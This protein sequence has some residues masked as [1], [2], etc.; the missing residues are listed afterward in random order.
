MMFLLP[1]TTSLISWWPPF[2]P[3]VDLELFYEPSYR[4]TGVSAFIET[5]ALSDKISV[6]F[7]EGEI[8]IRVKLW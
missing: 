7:R 8:F 6:P 3:K 4:A 1:V 5:I 2:S